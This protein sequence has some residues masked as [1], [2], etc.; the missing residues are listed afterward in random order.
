MNRLKVILFFFSLL[1]AVNISAIEHPSTLTGEV[2]LHANSSNRI[3]TFLQA[4]ADEVLSAANI[5]SQ[6]PE[7]NQFKRTLELE[8][9][10]FE[11]E[12]LENGPEHV[13]LI[14]DGNRRW[15]RSNSKSDPGFGHCFG[16]IRLAQIVQASI[17]LQIKQ[18]TVYALSS[19][20]LKRSRHEVSVLMSLV[21]NF[22]DYWEQDLLDSNVQI[23]HLGRVQGLDQAVIDTIHRVVDLTRENQG[24]KL[25]IAFN[26]GSWQE[27]TDAYNS[28]S[29][30]AVS[31]IDTTMLADFLYSGK[32]NGWTDP[33]LLI[34][35][36]G[37]QRLS[38]LLLLQ[39]SY[40]ELTFLPVL[41]P[42]FTPGMLYDAILD[43]D[44]ADRR[45]G[46]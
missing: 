25:N 41:W 5:V 28:L 32:L 39:V 46:Q 27:V 18:L 44:A 12:V 14:M 11:P 23:R 3:A 24:L 30:K 38:N 22:L 35:T 19:E 34:R 43:Y 45:Y 4:I 17:R 31:E 10:Q 33:D 20:N 2:E 40:T 6:A 15:A 36:G 21:K 26:Y 7:L 42:D 16:A 37:K 29:R 13:V 8:L 1:C 9:E